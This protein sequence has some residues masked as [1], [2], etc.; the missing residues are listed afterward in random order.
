MREYIVTCKT[1]EDLQSLYDDMETPG[2]NLYIPDREVE[3]KHRRP[4]SRN[5]HYMLTDE[6]A[7]QIKQDSRVLDVALTPEERGAVIKPL[8]IIE[9]EILEEE[10]QREL[11]NNPSYNLTSN[12]WSKT[13]NNSDTFRNW[14]MIRCVNEQTFQ[15]GAM[16]T[17]QTC[18]VEQHYLAHSL[19]LVKM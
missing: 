2:G 12:R 11:N 13:T 6:E 9:G 4:I 1:K 16:T 10:N 18:L 14:G 7:E 3:L 19:A 15:T 5:T 8:Y 17:S